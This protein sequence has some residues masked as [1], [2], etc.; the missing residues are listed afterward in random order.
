MKWSQLTHPLARPVSFP[1]TQCAGCPASSSKHTLHLPPPC[2]AQATP[3]AGRTAFFLSL[4]SSIVPFKS[5]QLKLII[6]SPVLPLKLVYNLF[7]YL[8]Q[9]ALYYNYLYMLHTRCPALSMEQQF[10]LLRLHLNCFSITH[11]V[12]HIVGNQSYET[13]YKEDSYMSLLAL[14]FYN[15]RKAYSHF[16]ILLKSFLSLSTYHEPGTIQTWTLT[17]PRAL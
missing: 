1:R 9:T 16:Q 11:R 5:T 4:A 10:I 8:Q 3:T 13:E 14:K 12:L 15:Y 7:Q 2:P 17:L 6:L